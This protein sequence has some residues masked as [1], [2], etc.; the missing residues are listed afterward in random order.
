MKGAIIGDIIGSYVEILEYQKKRTYQDRM[1][2]LN[3]DTPLITNDCSI[4]D[5]SVLTV[6]IA[7][8]LLSDRNYEKYLRI[9]GQRELNI[10]LDRYGRSRFGD[11][12]IKW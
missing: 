1:S 10:G 12:F 3:N 8:A 4:T 9:Y 7:D 5:D 2:S 11:S 6:A